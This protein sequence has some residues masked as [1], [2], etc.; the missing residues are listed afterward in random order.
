METPLV[1]N[2]QKYSIHD[3]DGI[4]TTIFFKGC[5][6][7]CQWCHNPESQ[8]FEKEL[9]LH[10]HKCTACGM[11]VKKCPNGANEIA[12]GKLVFHRDRC[13]A[14]GRCIDWCMTET[15]EIAGKEY[16]VDELL[17]EAKKDLPFYEQSGG[18]VTLSGGEVMAVHDMDF[19][20]ELCRRLKREGISV[21]IDTSGFAPYEHFERVLPYVDAFL[22]DIKSIDP[23]EHRADVGVDNTLILANLIR[24]ARDGAKLY[25]RL[26]IV[27]GKNDETEHIVQLM[28]F[29]RENHIEPFR[30]NLLPYHDIGKGKYAGLDR[31]YD[32]ESMRVPP[33]E[34]MEEL[35]T[36]FEAHGFHNI[37]IGG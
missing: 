13:T 23:D 5:P 6:L 29:L 18:G 10:R 22:Y 20:A 36:M 21:F 28:D 12:D 17:K 3:G 2:I 35:K 11:C 30:I 32:E 1:F 25:L 27:E 7:R 37:K 4:R 9:I 33:K 31:P 16:T 26:P 14:C 8:R 34:R 24:L 15:R 19:V